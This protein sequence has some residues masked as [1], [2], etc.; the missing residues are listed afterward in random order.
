MSALSWRLSVYVY[1]DG[2]ITYFIERS[3]APEKLRHI[4]DFLRPIAASPALGE[5]LR[6]AEVASERQQREPGDDGAS[7]QRRTTDGHDRHIGSHRHRRAQD[8]RNKLAP[9]NDLRADRACFGPMCL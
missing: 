1:D 5:G 6:G 8:E 3:N 9:N 7:N 2:V 4:S